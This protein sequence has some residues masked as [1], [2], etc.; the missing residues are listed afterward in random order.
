MGLHV[1]VVVSLLRELFAAH[2]TLELLDL[3]VHLHV[4]AEV[5]LFVE[6]FSAVSE[7]TH[8]HLVCLRIHR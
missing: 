6:D 2:L 4:Q 8:E 7:R 5:P 3:V 1:F